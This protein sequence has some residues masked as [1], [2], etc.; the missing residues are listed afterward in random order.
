M[1]TAHR[2]RSHA[3]HQS[4]HALA[5]VN[6]LAANSEQPTENADRIMVALRMAFEKLKSGTKDHTQFD[7]LAAAI[8]VGLIR[9][10]QID[11][12]AAE[13]MVR[14]VSAMCSCDG[15]AKRHG[16]YGFTGPDLLDLGEALDLYEQILRL[17]T[18]KQMLDALDIAAA[19]MR[20]QLETESL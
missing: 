11:P 7:R 19:R 15:I 12:L 13:T 17:S 2:M 5:A 4:R 6:T 16:R 3:K 8:N 9:A 10:E 14:G 18:P 20:G 1:N